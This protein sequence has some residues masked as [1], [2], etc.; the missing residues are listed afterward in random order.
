MTMRT[1]EHL[2]TVTGPGLAL[3]I[4]MLDGACVRAAPALRWCLG[5]TREEL[6]LEFSKRSYTATIRKIELGQLVSLG[7]AD[8]T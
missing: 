1:H 7:A 3:G 4:I 8:E 5:K 6:R 2:V